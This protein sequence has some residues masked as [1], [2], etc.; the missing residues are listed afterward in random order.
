MPNLNLLSFLLALMSTMASAQ[1]TLIINDEGIPPITHYPSSV[2]NGDEQVWDI[3]QDDQGMIYL[4]TMSAI[5][6]FDGTTWSKV[7][8]GD[9]KFQGI[10][11]FCKNDRGTIYVISAGDFGYLKTNQLGKMV[12]Q[13]L[14]HLLPEA[15]RN[16]NFIR[17]EYS[18]GKLYSTGMS[19]IRIFDESD[20][21]MVY[22]EV[23]EMT[24]PSI[25]TESGAYHAIGTR[26]YFK[27][28]NDSLIPFERN[29]VFENQYIT[30]ALHNDDQILTGSSYSGMFSISE[31]TIIRILQFDAPMLRQ[32][33]FYCS[34]MLNDQYQ[35]FGTLNKGL[36]VY[37][38]DYNLMLK[39]DASKGMDDA[40]FCIYVDDMNNAW[41]GSNKGA[42]MIDFQSAYS[43]IDTRLGL[44]GVVNV[45]E[46]DNGKLYFGSTEGLYA[47]DWQIG[48]TQKEGYQQIDRLD[49]DGGYV[50]DLLKGQSKILL[51]TNETMGEIDGMEF[52]KIRERYGDATPLTYLNDS[53]LAMTTGNNN[54]LLEVFE[55]SDQWNYS[56][57]IKFDQMP[58]NLIYLTYDPKND[59]YWASN[60]NDL[61]RFNLDEGNRNV[62]DYKFYNSENGLPADVYNYGVMVDGSVLFLTGQGIYEYHAKQDTFVISDLLE[63]VDS[64]LP[65]F[66]FV[67]GAENEYWYV[68]GAA[69]DEPGFGK[70]D[71]NNSKIEN[72][73][74][75][76]FSGAITEMYH[77]PGKGAL[78]GAYGGVYYFPENKTENYSMEMPVNIRLVEIIANN[79]DSI[80]FHGNHTGAGELITPDDIEKYEFPF[81]NNALRFTYSVPYFR[82]IDKIQYQIRLIGFQDEWSEWSRN[83]VKEFTNLKAGKY[84][85]QARAKN[86]FGTI[87]P[88]GEF[89]FRIF[90]PW[91]LT[92]W[93]YFFYLILFIGLVWLLVKWNSRRLKIENQR[94]EQII[95]ERTSEIL[96]QKNIIEKSLAE[97]ESLLK[98]IHHR[99]KNNLQIIASLLYLQSGKFENEDFKKVLEEG[100]GRVRS[101]ALIHQKLYEN[102]DLKSI[103]FGEYLQE[104]L[105]EIKASFGA[106]NVSLKIDAD[107]IQFDVETAVPL[108]LIVNELATNAFKYAFEGLE[109][110]T[111]SIMLKKQGDQFQLEIADDGKGI[112][113]EID[114]R[115]TK[116]LGLRLVKMLSV[117]LEGEYEF[118]TKNGTVFKMN[119]AA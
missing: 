37:D 83:T 78:V 4:G 33:N 102:E 49:Y 56:H 100:Q 15:A 20:S 48:D 101:M 41:I 12:Y 76:P 16:D 82:H 113:E 72:R 63:S 46:E 52:G 68:S 9:V 18:D 114:I 93:A 73:M 43:I 91:Y 111:F 84:V 34:E 74:S 30:I 51:N 92:A 87:S 38:N 94:L 70:I 31:D 67:A 110:G 14:N 109:E 106:E 104:L 21:S 35:L 44:E 89:E 119:F 65:L 116:S 81:V 42:F 54:S 64:T 13:S 99:V 59:C 88:I 98:E 3:I 105:G 58:S 11:S 50:S 17:C 79:T 97:R 107:D 6:Q 8:L 53:T 112:P 115:R 108:G 10:T 7:P 5:I 95:E 40:I 47:K 85:F 26:G 36:I 19:S 86:V 71:L 103:P 27:L 28:Q 23:G 118:E 60:I 24:F 55:Y 66:D 96:D 39:L 75:R 32:S 61:V 80:I 77:S 2:Y 57:T 45:I 69:S 62:T 22:K 29:Q 90:P 117:Q 1:S 25:Y